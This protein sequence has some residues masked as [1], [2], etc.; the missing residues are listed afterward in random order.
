MYCKQERKSTHAE[1]LED[2]VEAIVW[3]IAADAASKEYG[4]CY[5]R[6]SLQMPL[7]TNYFD[8]TRTFWSSVTPQQNTI[9]F[10][11]LLPFVNYAWN[12]IRETML[13]FISR[14]VVTI[15]FKLSFLCHS[16]QN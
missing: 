2:D 7:E 12:S 9:A 11:I 14:L 1:G 13:V 4:E 6:H 8:M 15:T 3:S 10:N 5:R 16:Q